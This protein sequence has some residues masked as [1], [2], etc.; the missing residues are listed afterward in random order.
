MLAVEHREREVVAQLLDDGAD[1]RAIEQIVELGIVRA[2]QLRIRF[3]RRARGLRY[4]RVVS[5]G[6]GIPGGPDADGAAR[7]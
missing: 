5:A 7:E 4:F 1:R 6:P 3:D 2:R